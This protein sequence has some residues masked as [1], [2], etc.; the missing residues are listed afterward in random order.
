M[1][2]WHSELCYP[3]CCPCTGSTGSPLGYR[4]SAPRPAFQTTP[5]TYNIPGFQ[6]HLKTEGSCFRNVFPSCP[7]DSSQPRLKT[8]VTISDL[9]YL[10][11]EDSYITFLS[12]SWLISLHHGC[13]DSHSSWTKTAS[14]FPVW[15]VIFISAEPEAER[16]S[17]L[18]IW[19]I[20]SLPKIFISAVTESWFEPTVGGES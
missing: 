8:F 7:L 12:G 15:S 16:N 2:P 13:R 18:W 14:S 20:H 4:T 9:Q 10:I 19:G 5:L 6:M 11:L 17:W 3:K 1:G